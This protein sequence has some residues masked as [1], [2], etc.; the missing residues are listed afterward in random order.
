MMVTIA[1]FV[2]HCTISIAADLHV[3][4]VQGNDTANGH[5]R[6]VKN[7]AAA[8]R[9]A[10]PGDTIHLMPDTTY[11]DW[12][13]FFDKS[14]EVDKPITLD[15]HGATLDGCDPLHPREWNEFEPGLFCHDDLL[16]LTDAI[17]DRW[18]FVINGQLNRTRRYS[19]GPSEPLK[20]P[21]D[22]LPPIEPAP[23]TDVA[24]LERC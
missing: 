8:I 1:F 2:T 18:F 3:D 12:A 4:P 21:T 16:P 9:L 7:L 11:H 23:Q 20:S 13:A 6:P 5:E 10:S 14:G 15:G 24:S 22:L 19:K 17:I